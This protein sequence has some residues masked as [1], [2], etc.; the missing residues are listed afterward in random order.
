MS[1][2]IGLQC[3]PP[4]ASQIYVKSP[5]IRYTFEESY[6]ESCCCKNITKSHDMTPVVA[7]C[8]KDFGPS[9]DKLMTWRFQLGV[10][11]CVSLL[12]GYGFEGKNENTIYQ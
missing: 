11:S 2:A 10:P 7:V 12:V 6:Q 3:S 1:A 9:S 5:H 4:N 8:V